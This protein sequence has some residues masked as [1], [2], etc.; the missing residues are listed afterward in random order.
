M[1]WRKNMSKILSIIIVAGLIVGGYLTY[2]SHNKAVLNPENKVMDEVASDTDKVKE[3]PTGKKM[4]FSEFIKQGGA[5]K[6]SVQQSVSGTE[7]SGTVYINSGD[8]RG[9]FST[10]TEGMSIKTN[11]I[12]HDGYSYTWS[13]ALPSMGFKVKIDSDIKGDG[14]APMQGSY[15]WDANQIGDYSCDSWTVD[16]SKFAIPS[17]VKFTEIAK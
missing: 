14:S 15:T 12:M 8:M 17:N 1:F 6:C 2:K 11:F 16:S 9:D 3:E 10:T 7:S 5:Y 4:A 13:S